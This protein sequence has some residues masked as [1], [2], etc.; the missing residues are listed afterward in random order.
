M[1]AWWHTRL[2]L[3]QQAL[4]NHLVVGHFFFTTQRAQHVGSSRSDYLFWLFVYTELICVP[5]DDTVAS[6]EA[7]LHAMNNNVA[8]SVT[9]FISEQAPT[10]NTAT[11]DNLQDDPS[12]AFECN[13]CLELAKDPVCAFILKTVA[14]GRGVLIAIN[15][16]NAGRGG[17]RSG[18]DA[19]RTSILLALPVQ[20]R[21]VYGMWGLT[22]KLFYHYHYNILLLRCV[23]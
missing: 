1:D 4:C 15:I 16:L 12:S 22:D 5:M 18:C 21:N 19:V 8:N 6:S 10:T 3:V 17:V 14:C 9:T 11:A 23:F 2:S 7:A 20:V 13:I